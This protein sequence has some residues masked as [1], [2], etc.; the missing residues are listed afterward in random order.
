LVPEQGGLGGVA[1]DLA[2]RDGQVLLLGL[3]LGVVAEGHAVL[4][5]LPF[6][7]LF[8]RPRVRL[9]LGSV[10]GQQLVVDP[11]VRDEDLVLGQRPRF[12]RADDG[13]GAEGLDGFKIFD[14][15]PML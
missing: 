7:K 15:G 14:L 6:G 1:E 9:G 4:Q 10:D 13:G 3:E 11:E 2:L 8:V 12:V 5:R